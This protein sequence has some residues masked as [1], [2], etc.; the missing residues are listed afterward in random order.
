VLSLLIPR[1]IA[2]SNL[3]PSTIFRTIDLEHCTLLIDEAD[4]FVR[5]RKD[6]GNEDLRGL[7]NSGHTRATAYVIR[8]VPAGEKA[9][10]P[11]RF[12]TWCPIAIAGIGGLPD[13]VEDRSITIR[14]RRKLRSEKV[15][16]LTRRNKAARADAATLASKLARFA[17]DNLDKLRAADPASP[18]TLNDRATDNWEH[19]LAIADLASGDWPARARAAAVK[20]S[21]D[22]EDS[23]WESLHT[24]L[25]TDIKAIFEAQPESTAELR[26]KDI[27]E[28]LAQIETSPWAE[29]GRGGK[30][31]THA[32]LARMLK[33]FEIYVTKIENGNARGYQKSNFSDAFERYLAPIPPTQGV[34]VSET[35]G[36]EGESDDFKVSSE[37]SQDTLEN[38]E[39]P[40][41]SGASDTWTASEG[42]MSAALPDAPA[43]ASAPGLRRSQEEAE[44]DRVAAEDGWNPNADEAEIK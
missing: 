15:E 34:K 29:M 32:R 28:K 5:T 42:G 1:S 4:T 22:R 30:P 18:E 6:A 43:A 13:T 38:A 33:S 39:T 23:D 14:M 25:L 36:R 9:W 26:S 10:Q 31:I 3:S 35:L 41:P 19:L 12:S 17:A 21:G 24:K 16:R 2:A 11:K 20:L 40:T 8:N 7:L 27:C 44:I 37:F